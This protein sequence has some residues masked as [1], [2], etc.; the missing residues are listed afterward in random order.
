MLLSVL[1]MDGRGSHREVAWM[2]KTKAGKLLVNCGRH[3]QGNSVYH[4]NGNPP[5]GEA[6]RTETENV[7]YARAVKHLQAC[8][9]GGLGRGKKE[10]RGQKCLK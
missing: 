1:R 8:I 4:I 6:R 5:T 7:T 2:L 9:R 3:R 10:Q